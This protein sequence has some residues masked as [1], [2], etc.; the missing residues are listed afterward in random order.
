MFISSSDIFCTY[1]PRKGSERGHYLPTWE[2]S[3]IKCLY[4]SQLDG[5]RRNNGLFCPYVSL[6]FSLGFYRAQAASF[7]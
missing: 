6:C 5:Y 1:F 3:G 4:F 2:N 7:L